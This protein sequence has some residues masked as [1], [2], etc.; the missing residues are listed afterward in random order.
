KARGLPVISIAGFIRQGAVGFVVPK[1]TKISSLADFIGKEVFYTTSSFE[2]PF[3][4][5]LFRANGVDFNRVNLVNMD[6]SAKIPA[7]LSGRG[8]AMITT[9]PPNIVIAAGKRDSYGVLF[10]NYGFSLPSFGLVTRTDTLKTRAA[11]V[12]RFAS[13]VATAWTYIL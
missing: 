8:D 10:A 4:D 1:A 9:V 5:P 6:A 13:I 3:V 7:Y 2:G 11:A 12:R